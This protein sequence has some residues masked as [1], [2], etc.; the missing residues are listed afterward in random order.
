[1]AEKSLQHF[2]LDLQHTANP[3]E[4]QLEY[5]RVFEIAAYVRKEL[6][7]CSSKSRS[8]FFAA[9]AMDL[10]ASVCII[11]AQQMKIKFCSDLNFSPILSPHDVAGVRRNG[12]ALVPV[13]M[14]L[15]K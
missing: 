14:I 9:A 2:V 6:L 13:Q 8:H 1:M 11:N 5:G 3:A 15:I 4:L 12:E 10:M 7:R